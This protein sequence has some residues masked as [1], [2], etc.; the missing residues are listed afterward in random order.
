MISTLAPA[1]DV[2]AEHRRE[3]L[4]WLPT[5]EV[6][7]GE[8]PTGEVPTG[9]VPAG[10]VPAGDGPRPGVV[11]TGRLRVNETNFHYDLRRVSG[12]VWCIDVTSEPAAGDALRWL[13]RQ[14]TDAARRNGLVPVTIDR[15]F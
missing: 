1:D 2:E 14:L 7:T 5:G 9:E 10:E 15:L 4:R 3:A 8:V 12:V 11:G 6:P 13:L